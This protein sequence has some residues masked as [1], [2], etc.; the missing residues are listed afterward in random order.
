ML[1]PA[2]F[3]KAALRSAL[4]A[5]VLALAVAPAS[6]QE[7]RLPV[8]DGSIRFAVIGDT[9]TASTAQ[10][11]VAKQMAASTSGLKMSPRFAPF[12]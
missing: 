10:Y 11:D 6:A 3:S 4:A 7:L 8:K 1:R 9:G 2:P 12:R 5:L